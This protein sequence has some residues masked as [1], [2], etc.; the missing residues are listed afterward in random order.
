MT[1]SD[2]HRQL[3]L[4]AAIKPEV[5]STS[6]IESTPTGIAFPWWDGNGTRLVQYRPDNP[7]MNEQGK[8]IK[9][10]FPAGSKMILNQLRE[11]GFGPVLICEGTKQQYAALSWAPENYSVYGMA[12]CWCWT[13]ADLLPF[14][15]RDVLI[16]FDGDF[17]SNRDV[18]DAA[19]QFKEALEQHAASSVKFVKT[20]ARG[21][22]GLDDV[23][24]RLP[25]GKRSELLAL[26]ISQAVDKLP[27]APAKRDKNPF[28]EK[29]ALQVRTATEFL[30]EKQ[31]AALT[32]ER[33]VALYL[34]GAYHIDGSAFLAAVSRMLDDQ[35]RPNWRA[36][37]EDV[38]IGI[39][40]ESATLLPDRSPHQ[41]LNVSNGML[42]LATL[43][44]LEH[45]PKYLSVRQVPVE[46]DPSARCPTYEAWLESACGSQADDLEEVA[47][48]MLDP[49]R[50]PSKAAFLFGPSRSGKSTFLRLMQAIA[51]VEN[52]TAVTLHELSSDRFAAANVYG[53][54][55]NSAADLSSAH[56]A[57]L[58]VFKMMT[59][60]DP[61]Q[62]NR[63][64]GN[65]FTF[66]NQALFAF[67]AN[68]LPTVSETSRAYSERIKPFEFP[69][70]FA[71]KENPAI[72]AGML[73]ELPGIL[74]RWVAAYRRVLARGGF[75]ATDERVR[76]EFET[77]SDRVAQFVMEVCQI[78]EAK[79]GQYLPVTQCTKRR[80]LAQGFKRWAERNGGHPM[81]ER[82]VFERMRQIRDVVEVR[83]AGTKARAF[84]VVVRDDD[85]FDQGFSPNEDRNVG[86]EAESNTPS[87]YVTTT[88]TNV[89]SYGQGGLENA[90]LPTPDQSQAPD[91]AFSLNASESPSLTASASPVV[92]PSESA[93]TVAFD[94][95]TCSVDELYQ[96]S[97][98]VRIGALMGPTGPT[99]VGH[100]MDILLRH[101][102]QAETITGHNILGFDLQALAH[103]HG[104]DYE[105][106]A[107]KSVDTMIVDR[108]LNPPI[109]KG[110]GSVSLNDL[111]ARLGL[112]MKTDDIKRLARNHGGFDLI[113]MDDAD[114]VSYLG[115]DVAAS[116]AVYEALK[117]VAAADP[118]ITREHRVQA[119]MG[120][121]SLNGFRVNVPL[122]TERHRAGQDKLNSI[123]ERLHTAYGFPTGGAAPQRSKAGK[124][125]FY[126]ALKG[127][128]IGESWLAQNWPKN[129]DGTLSLGKEVLTEKRELFDGPKPDAA[130]LCDAI[131][132]MN[133]V[134]S[135]YG[136][137]LDWLTTEG[138]VHPEISP[139]QAS[140]RWSVTKPGLTVVGKK[141][142]KVHER[143]IYLPDEGHVLVAFDADQ[144]DMRAIAAESQDRGYM[145]LFLPKAD[146]SKVDP[147]TDI[148]EMVG[149]SR[150][151]AK[152]IGHGYNYGLGV[153]GQVRNG[154]EREKAE[155]FAQRMR[156]S[157]PRLEEWKSEI[158]AQGEAS[159]LLTNG[160]GRR[161]R[162]NPEWAYTQ[163]P[164]LMGQGGTRDLLAEGLLKLPAEIL[165]MLRVVI[166]D[167][168]VLS[169]PRDIVEDVCRT[170][171][172]CMTFE[173]RGVPIT[174]GT[175][176]FGDN[177]SLCY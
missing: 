94:L 2:Q 174:W 139:E 42:N 89:D 77:K 157:F 175:S 40:F 147:H 123:K 148:A 88:K 11:T 111:A 10:R 125:A 46:W 162:L 35:Y 1:L 17:V 124:E 79:E 137:C 41:L 90:Y 168:L 53:K 63:K 37:M 18:Y 85:T 23:L 133:G 28:F 9:Y 31:P 12:G 154:V 44:L 142:E 33:K 30:L 76:K 39:L 6:G 68:E 121:M 15:G 170:V 64:Y 158:R 129:K 160:F 62:G 107:A 72:E 45:S 128:G 151:D 73:E 49:S 61:I 136:N 84:N 29:G 57:D 80:D 115:G 132:E 83:E 104:A 146:G 69:N 165:P 87:L 155:Q 24:A 8:P 56:V 98:F 166:H 122:V 140:G 141:G 20:P 100:R 92:W 22:D 110:K 156:D 131:L 19:S 118:Y 36:A 117:E 144:V 67:S 176:K 81:G 32:S 145:N 5:I 60:E 106:L 169:I 4:D 120:R 171:V 173:H 51:G 101:L 66:T 172:D 159:G 103:H 21:T 93:S 71:G 27:K 97:D 59:G 65:Q 152:V 127:S 47:S 74:V 149:L 50:T 177:W 135:I 82:K 52:R 16:V 34:N 150:Q 102:N 58:S 96:R 55:L 130:A 112:P 161:M 109:S 13:D 164:A 7:P 95:E 75:L 43:E 26:W 116:Q 153:N 14:M 119:I 105:A 167:E 143:A 163:A 54:M 113:P 38:A 86:R 91:Q 134:R 25:E 48:T 108:Q 70:S 138:R 99:H 3:L 78:F 126:E 114:Y